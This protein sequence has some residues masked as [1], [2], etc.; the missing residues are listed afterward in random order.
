MSNKTYTYLFSDLLD[1][2]DFLVEA[3]SREE[4][5]K[6]AHYYFGR[7]KCYGAIP[8]SEAEMLGYDTY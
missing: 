8:E 1:G 5:I 3:P 6:I 4:A 2:E 7:V